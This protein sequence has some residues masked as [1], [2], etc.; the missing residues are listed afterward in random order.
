MINP[1]PTVTDAMTA[2]NKMDR[3]IASMT[4]DQIV[5]AV[6]LLEVENNYDDAKRLTRG[7]LV[8]AYEARYGEDKTDQLL[9]IA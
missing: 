8:S 2:R 5:D 6:Q 4:H 3:M 7:K 1:T 9:G